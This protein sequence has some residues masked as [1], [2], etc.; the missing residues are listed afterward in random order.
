M[1]SS[2]CARARITSSASE[3]IDSLA[4]STSC[5]RCRNS[6]ITVLATFSLTRKRIECLSSRQQVNSLGLENFPGVS[7]AS[8]NVFRRQVVVFTKNLLRRPASTEQVHDEFD[9]DAGALDDR[10][11]RKHLGIDDDSIMP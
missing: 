8:L 6:W 3:R 5:P 1:R 4:E 10:L 11:A 9:G 7:Q 2:I